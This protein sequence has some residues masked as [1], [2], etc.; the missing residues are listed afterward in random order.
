M[1]GVAAT[2][3][4]SPTSTASEAVI[5][6]SGGVLSK[7]LRNVSFGVGSATPVDADAEVCAEELS[8]ISDLLAAKT[9][10]ILYSRASARGAEPWRRGKGI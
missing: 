6:V 7:N 2:E 3:L 5:T 10:S 9:Y 8:D 1:A 4:Y